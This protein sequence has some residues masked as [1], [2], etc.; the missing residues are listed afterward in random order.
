ML[1]VFA[2]LLK[3]EFLVLFRGR[4]GLVTLLLP[5]LMQLVLFGYAATFDV[6]RVPIAIMNEDLGPQGR[7]LVARF[8]GLPLFDV[9]A[10]PSHASQIERMIVD[11][12]IV[13]ALRIGQRFSADL[14]GG[15]PTDAQV[16]VDGRI[17]NTAM[18]AQTY[19]ASVIA[20]FN[21]ERLTLGGLPQPT[22]VSVTRAWFN[23]NLLS[24]WYI[25]PGLVAK[26]L[27][28]VTLASAALSLTHERSGGTLARLLVAPLAPSL[29]LGA[30][31]A[32]ALIVGM[33]QGFAL[34][35]IAILWFEVPFRGSLFLLALSLAAM[36]LSTIGIGTMIS[37]IAR[38]EARAVLCSLLF[39]V[40]AV[41]LSGFATPIA[42]MPEWIQTLS[43]VNPL[44]YF[45]VAAR[46]LFLRGSGWDA[47]W[48]QLWPMAL[49]GTTTLGTAWLFLRRRLD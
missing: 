30:K 45:I 29:I 48:P 14:D 26:I 8:D 49:I 12:D 39:I 41:M 17:L 5:P 1:G 11:G 2:V 43:M 22:A 10:Q 6:N 23:P 34:A 9:V 19:A 13:L 21:R 27:M 32:A 36:L 25:V 35:A 40:P 28:I 42:A 31:V 4:R 3:K 38:T 47:V 15:R 37:S 44:R 46:S 7:E 33:L 24:H 16:I 20:Q 18:F